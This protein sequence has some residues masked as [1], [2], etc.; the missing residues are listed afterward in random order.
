MELGINEEWEE[1]ESK[2]KET[3]KKVEEECG[4]E[5]ERKNR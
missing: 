1:I 3:L 2:I 5:K 4:L